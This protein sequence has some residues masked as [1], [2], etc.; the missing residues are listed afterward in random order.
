MRVDAHQHFWRLAA[1]RG[2]WPPPSLAA[3]HRDFAP[4]DLAPELAAEERCQR[5]YH[6]RCLK[7][8][9]E[10]KAFF[11]EKKKQKAFVPAVADC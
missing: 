8:G 11:F 9:K 4:D 2:Q 1:R 5:Q 10:S 6:A 3:I 7:N